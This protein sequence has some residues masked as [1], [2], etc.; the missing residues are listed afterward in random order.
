MNNLVLDGNQIGAQGTGTLAAALESQPHLQQLSLADCYITDA[1]KDTSG[2]AQLVTCLKTLKGLKELNVDGCSLG[3]D[4][5]Q[6]VC[7]WLKD[8]SPAF[9]SL[10]AERS[11]NK[12]DAAAE[13]MLREKAGKHVML[14]LER[15]RPAYEASVNRTDAL[16]K[17]ELARRKAA[18]LNGGG[19]DAD[20]LAAGADAPDPSPPAGKKPSGSSPRGHGTRKRRGSTGSM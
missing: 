19:L 17:E 16:L 3:A 20:P 7:S 14:H 15:S 8:V 18:L 1:G 11:S 9:E 13:A 12:L 5:A 10:Y 4:G 2:L 6:L